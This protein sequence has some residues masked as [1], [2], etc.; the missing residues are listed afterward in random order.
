M[1]DGRWP[2]LPRHTQPES[3]VQALL[4]QIRITSRRNL[5]HASNRRSSR[6]P[7]PPVLSED[8]L[9]PLLILK[10][11]FRSA[12]SHRLAGRT[13]WTRNAAL[14]RHGAPGGPAQMENTGSGPIPEHGVRHRSDSSVIHKLPVSSPIEKISLSGVEFRPTAPVLGMCSSDRAASCRCSTG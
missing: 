5:R 6:R 4:D 2:V 12:D 3:D 14:Q 1:L 8:L 9:A 11:S 10:D 13:R 7:R